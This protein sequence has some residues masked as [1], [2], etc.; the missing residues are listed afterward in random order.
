MF[1]IINSRRFESK[2]RENITPHVFIYLTNHHFFNQTS[3]SLETE[4]YLYGNIDVYHICGAPL[5]G[6]IEGIFF[7]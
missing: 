4:T 3:I 2:T 1:T 6:D 5:Y 7:I